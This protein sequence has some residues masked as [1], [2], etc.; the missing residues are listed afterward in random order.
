MAS[1][2]EQIQ[3]D[4]LD[5]SVHISDLLRRMKLAA[6]KLGLGSLEDWVEHEL[7]GYEQV[8]VPEYRVVSGLPMCEQRHMGRLPLTGFVEQLSTRRM[9]FSVAA[10]EEYANAPDEATICF[11]FSDKIVNDINRQ[12][13]MVGVTV[14]LEVDRSAFVAI[15]DRV[16]TLVLD[17]ALEM[18]K[19]G[20]RGTEFSFDAA[21]RTKAQQATSIYIGSI[22]TFAGNLGVGN[23]AGDV[24]LVQADLERVRDLADQLRA[25]VDELS[26]AGADGSTLRARLDELE[27]ELKKSTPPTSVLRGLLVD[28]RNALAGA[29]GNLMASGAMTLIN[30]ILATGVPA[31]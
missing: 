10:L 1:I 3:R 4:A 30:K 18:E 5:R 11:P 9:G 26:A 14:V 17:W 6:S 19:A 24:T 31:P 21:D 27:L 22:G 7:N 20:V 23:T 12:N 13:N 29:A 16:R 15:L 28:V 25:H 8:P 2:I